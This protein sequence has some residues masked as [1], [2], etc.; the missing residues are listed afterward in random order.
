MEIEILE[1]IPCP[2]QFIFGRYFMRPAAAEM[3][4]PSPTD[5]FWT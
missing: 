2:G 5:Y 3:N 4:A 1:K